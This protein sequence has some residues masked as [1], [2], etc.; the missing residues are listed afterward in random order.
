[1]NSTTGSEY[2]EN[3]YI[4][5]KLIFAFAAQ[6]SLSKVR[7]NNVRCL[8]A[9][10]MGRA[11]TAASVP[12]TQ[13]VHRCQP[14]RSGRDGTDIKT[15]TQRPARPLIVPLLHARRDTPTYCIVTPHNARVILVGSHG[16]Q[17]RTESGGSGRESIL[18][19]FICYMC[20]QSLV[21][22]ILLAT[23]QSHT[24]HLVGAVTNFLV[25]Q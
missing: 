24:C 17:W 9:R 12:H 25:I 5:L 23:N 6:P 14:S 19:V 4:H 10:D 16:E 18:R 21:S 1:M 15:L 7:N 3:I 22:L 2:T 20:L 8:H 11:H 13:T